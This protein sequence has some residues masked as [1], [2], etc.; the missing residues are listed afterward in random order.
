MIQYI[1]AVC[2]FSAD[3][4]CTVSYPTSDLM[5]LQECRDAI[6]DFAAQ[7]DYTNSIMTCERRHARD[8]APDEDCDEVDCSKPIP[9]ED[10][11]RVDC[12][13]TAPPPS[14]NSGGDKHD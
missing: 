14:T 11:D 3:G 1:L 9:D 6:T 10:C 13:H 7:K 4:S 8:A 12:L 5:S 2:M